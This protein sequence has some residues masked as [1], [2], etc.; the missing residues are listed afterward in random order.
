MIVGYLFYHH[1]K[2][3]KFPTNFEEFMWLIGKFQPL[4]T[5]DQK[6]LA[7]HYIK[8]NFQPREKGTHEK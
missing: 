2:W 5:V 6:I 1:F 4:I 8:G 7:H 3:S